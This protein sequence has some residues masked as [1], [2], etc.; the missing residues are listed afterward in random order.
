MI[1]IGGDDGAAAGDLAAHELRRHESG[2]GGAEALPVG[3][4]RFCFLGLALPPD[5]LAM[6]DIDHF[7]GDD[8]GAGELE[9]RHRTP[10]AVDDPAGTQR[11]EPAIDVDAGFSF[12]IGAR[13]VVDAERGPVRQRD[14]AE[15]HHDIVMALRR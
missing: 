2:N 9:L 5:I 8:A 15:R 1:D 14:L 3:E 11:L 12:G 13:R 10:V 4:A 6:G 7:L